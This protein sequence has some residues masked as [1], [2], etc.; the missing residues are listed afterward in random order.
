MSACGTG[1]AKGHCRPALP[2]DLADPHRR[3]QNSRTPDGGEPILDDSTI[4]RVSAQR[5][6][7]SAALAVAPRDGGTAIAALS[8]SGSAK[9]LF[10]RAPRDAA[11]DAVWLNTAGGITGGDTFQLS[12]EARPG[13]RLRLT[14]QAAER[15]YRA[16]PGAPGAMTT[17][18]SVGHGA[19]CHWLP[20]ETILFDAAALTRSL[21]VD[22]TGDAAFLGCEALIFGRRAMGERVRDLRLSDRID[23]TRDGRAVYADRLRLS[24]DADAQLSRA[25]VG[26]G[27]GAMAT[28]IL[29][30][31]NAGDAADTLRAMLP[32]NAGASAPTDDVAV[33]RL[34]AEDGFELRRSLVPLLTHLAGA[35]L[36][37][38]W[39]I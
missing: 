39:M 35:P 21:R 13:A 25:F 2:P 29:A 19:I 9:L 6:R 11:L 3:A 28:L 10:P 27:A 17:Q 36:P 12:A 34:L 4:G 23:V 8:Q 1:R 16:L 31:P 7:G 30:R 18:L 5:A 33:V 32:A 15:I 24:G 26:G 22:L 14:T 20:Q 37:R 38:A